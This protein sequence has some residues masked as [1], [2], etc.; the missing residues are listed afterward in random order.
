MLSSFVSSYL[1]QEGNHSENIQHY[2]IKY[3]NNHL[4]ADHRKL[5]CFINPVRGLQSLKAAYAA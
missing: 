5:K 4:K 2:Q 1:L 3:R